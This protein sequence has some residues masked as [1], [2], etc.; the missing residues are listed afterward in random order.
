ML[1]VSYVVVFLAAI[2]LVLLPLGAAAFPWVSW[3][4]WGFA[5]GWWIGMILIVGLLERRRGR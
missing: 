2:L 4:R 3:E 1:R 5:A